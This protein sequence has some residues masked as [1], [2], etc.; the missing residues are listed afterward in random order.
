VVSSRGAPCAARLCAQPAADV[1]ED[2]ADLIA[3]HERV[4]EP[5]R[6]ALDTAPHTH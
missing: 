6:G 2:V 5:L 3:D 4:G 1:G